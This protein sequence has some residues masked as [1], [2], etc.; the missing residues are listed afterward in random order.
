MKTF[1]TL[2]GCLFL[3]SVLSFSACTD[4]ATFE[5]ALLNEWTVEG[6]DYPD[7]DEEKMKIEF[8]AEGLLTYRLKTDGWADK[9][10][11]YQIKDEVL[12]LSDEGAF[13]LFELPI[14]EFSSKKMEFGN[15]V[16][17]K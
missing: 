11:Y 10:G 2:L 15:G 4:D 6:L 5:E 16:V 9:S 14:G 17:F 12:Y 13:L 3:F 1:K 7:I 8:M